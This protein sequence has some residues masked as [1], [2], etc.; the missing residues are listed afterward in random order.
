M[1]VMSVTGP[2]AAAELGATLV[3]EHIIVGMP[4]QELDPTQA[5]DR[6][7]I[8]A[9]A[10]D[11]LQELKAHGVSTI[12]DPCPIELGRDPELYADVSERSG[13][14][15]VFAT[16]FYYEASGI[17]LYWRARDKEEIAEL[18]L[19][20]LE[21][22]VGNT[23]LR[24]G[25]IKAATGLDVTPLE[26]TVL[27][28]AA[29]AQCAADCAIITHTENSRHGDV[30]QA[31]FAEHGADPHRILIGHQDEQSD[32]EAIRQ[33]TEGNT[34][35]GID[36]V[37]YDILAPDERRADHVAALIRN[38]YVRQVCLSQD[39]I[40][41]MASPRLPFAM[42]PG[43]KMTPAAFLAG[44]KPLSY[45]VT[46][47]SDLLRERGVTDADL[48]IIFRDNPRRLLAGNE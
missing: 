24:P 11:K 27:A 13:V 45:V 5:P 22:G 38:G 41:T 18:Y 7:E 4:G 36:R 30:Q 44:N 1:A 16:G 17:P 40:C 33:L 42:P 3:H 32:W 28:A 6:R 20:E 25:I 9:M 39:C 26:R 31:I 34:F 23:G 48:D 43:Y 10:V 21:N 2:I 37:G 15:I 14:N 8:V 35:I 19:H 29:M 46:G 12:V 47:F